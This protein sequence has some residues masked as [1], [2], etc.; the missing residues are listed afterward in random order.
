VGNRRREQAQEREERL[1]LMTTEELNARVRQ[2]EEY[3]ANE[4]PVF[5]TA[6]EHYRWVLDRQSMHLPV[7]EAD[8]TFVAEFESTM[9][10]DT[11]AYWRIYKE[12]IGL[13]P[14]EGADTAP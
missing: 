7:E 4:R 8:I 5:A 12:G 2:M 6:T 1:R 14:I 10:A 9:D 3:A 11:A 13:I